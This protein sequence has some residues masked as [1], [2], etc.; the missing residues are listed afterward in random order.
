MAVLICIDGLRG[1]G[2]FRIR[3]QTKLSNKRQAQVKLGSEVK[4]L[5]VL[6]GKLLALLAQ[7]HAHLRHDVLVYEPSL[8]L[9]MLCNALLLLTLSLLHKVGV[10]RLLRCGCS[11]GRVQ[12]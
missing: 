11:Y 8:S 10:V 6:C 5:T 2:W 12:S 7:S 4:A 9:S 3:K 1:E